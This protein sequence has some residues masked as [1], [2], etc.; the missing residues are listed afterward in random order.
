MD[1]FSLLSSVIV[2]V[3]VSALTS[4]LTWFLALRKSK[5]DYR[6]GLIDE[7]S[8][9]VDKLHTEAVS[10]STK[11]YSDE[12]YHYMVYQGEDLE[13]LLLKINKDLSAYNFLTIKQ[14]LTDHIFH[15][16]DKK[17]VIE[18]LSSHFHNVKRKLNKHFV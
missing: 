2:P 5:N 8:Q 15:S 10:I 4:S 12:N 1:N 11:V 17:K 18:Q 6:N 3:V 13:T 9:K 14:I 7:I 16:N